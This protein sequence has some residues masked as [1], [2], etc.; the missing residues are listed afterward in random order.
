ML[1]NRVAFSVF[2]RAATDGWQS[3][4]VHAIPQHDAPRKPAD[5]NIMLWSS[6]DGKDNASS[7][8]DAILYSK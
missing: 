5:S 6:L 1:N 3:A 4:G 7:F 2:C 8:C